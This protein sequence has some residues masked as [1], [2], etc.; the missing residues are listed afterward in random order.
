M[1]A[2]GRGF[3]LNAVPSPA[4]H[5]SLPDAPVTWLGSQIENATVPG[6]LPP[7]ALPVT[8]ALS[9]RT[10]PSATGLVSARPLASDGVVTVVVAIWRTMKHSVFSVP[11]AYG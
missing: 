1:A 9:K 10:V 5:T 2:S 11:A 6:G 4:A 8:T 3:P 7:V